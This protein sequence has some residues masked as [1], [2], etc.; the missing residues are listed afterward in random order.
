MAYNVGSMSKEILR[1]ERALYL[2]E[3]FSFDEKDEGR[4]LRE[5]I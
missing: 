1:L 4:L 3:L 2:V 5:A